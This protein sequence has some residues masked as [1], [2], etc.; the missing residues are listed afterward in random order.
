M[1]IIVTEIIK[2]IKDSD[3]VIERDM[4]LLALF[5]KLFRTALGIALDQLDRELATEYKK[6]GYVVERRDRR[7]VQ[8]LCGTVSFVCRRMKKPGKKGI[9]PLDK[10]LRLKPYQRFSTLLMKKVAE[11]A[12]S[13]VY[14]KTADIVNRFT[15]TTLSHQTVKHIVMQSG[16]LCQEWQDIQRQETSVEETEAPVVYIEG[17]GLVLRGQHKK[18]LEIHRMQ[19][20]EGREKEG[21]RTRLIHAYHMAST[22]YEKT[23]E[24]AGWYMH[25]QYGLSHTIVISNGDGGTGYGY[26]AFQELAAGCK[27]HEHQRD[28]YHVHRKVKGTDELQ[29]VERLRK[30]LTR[31]WTYV[32]P[33]NQRQMPEKVHLIQPGACEAGHR[34][35]S[36]R[37]KHQGRCWSQEGAEAMVQLITAMKNEEWDAVYGQWGRTAY[38][39]IS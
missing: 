20:Y 5:F 18:Q 37:M 12:T 14:R 33:L 13:C 32:E 29:D 17:D 23:W 36:Y 9:Y 28:V 16:T 31:N 38:K 21:K 8:C 26:E 10:Q 4:K 3:T 34:I 2:T 19:V 6:Q 22:E 27:W 24:R 7:T 39:P 15:L 30:Y 35:Y 1:E 11:T 25:R